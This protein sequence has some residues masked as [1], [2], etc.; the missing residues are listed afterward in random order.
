MRYLVT[1]WVQDLFRSLSFPYGIFAVNII[2]CLLIGVVAGLSESRNFLTPEVRGLVIVGL[3]GG[4]TTFSALSYESFEL[5]RSG[6]AITAFANI[7]LSVAV[8][9]VAVWVGYSAAQAA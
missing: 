2:G 9:L 8:G 3:L 1:G 4:F 6:Q 5:L 7:F